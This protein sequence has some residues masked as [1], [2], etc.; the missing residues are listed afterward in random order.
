M[1]PPSSLSGEDNLHSILLSR[2]ALSKGGTEKG[3]VFFRF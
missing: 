3:S 2:A 1:A